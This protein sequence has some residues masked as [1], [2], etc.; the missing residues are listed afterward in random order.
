M[1]KIKPAVCPFC[2]Q[3]L[4]NSDAAEH[5]QRSQAAQER[6][7]QKRVSA[8]ANVLVEKRLAVERAQ[9]EKEA[10]KTQDKR[11]KALENMLK[12]IQEEKVQLERRVEKLSANE[13][14]DFHEIDVFEQ[15]RQAFPGDKFERHGKGPDIRQVVYYET[16]RTAQQAGVVVYEC[17]DTIRWQN[18]F[19]AQIRKAGT[20]QRT[21]Y[22]ILVTRAYPKGEKTVCVRDD[23]IV[24]Q[25]ALV[26]AITG[27]V[28]RMVI[29]AHR[30]GLRTD[31]HDEK[32]ARLFEYLSSNDFRQ[33]FSAIV[34]ASDGLKSL[35]S[36][37][38]RAHE[39]VW[40]RREHAYDDLGRKSSAVDEAIR[41][42][43]E[44]TSRAPTNRSL[45]KV[46]RLPSRAKAV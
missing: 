1:S 21:P 31:R 46:I 3:A 29:E 24:V 17:K 2:G 30:A 11:V 23:V 33:T 40:T 20:T 13:R 16:G 28:R 35:L 25:P 22:L 44:D 9:L 12:Q 27:I 6:E 37:E 15:L 42:I 41:N 32:T 8:D 36:E 10:A 14:G 38:K 43:I 45:A 34:A 39:R 19:V 7:L 5:L 4:V 26:C 18:G